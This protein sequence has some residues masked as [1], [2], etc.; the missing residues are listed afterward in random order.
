MVI[1]HDVTR[2][3]KFTDFFSFKFYNDFWL[4]MFTI[5]ALGS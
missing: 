2:G 1:L 4:N 3:A 5:R